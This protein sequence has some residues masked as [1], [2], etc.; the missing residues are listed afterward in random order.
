MT[1]DD[2]SRPTDSGTNTGNYGHPVPTEARQLVRCGLNAALATVDQASGHPYAS[3]ITVATLSEGTPIALL[4][5][6]ARHTRN[7]DRNTHASLLYEHQASQREDPL[8][9]ARLT[10]MGTMSPTPNPFAAQR[11]LARHPEA[12]QYAEFADFA[13]YSFA[14]EE[15]HFIGGFGRIE[16]LSASQLFPSHLSV[17]GLAKAEEE[18]I[19]ALNS[20]EPDCARRLAERDSAGAEPASEWRITGIDAAGIDL[21]GQHLPD[22]AGFAPY[23]TRRADFVTP[24]QSVAEVEARVDSLLA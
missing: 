16:T 5:G 4:S 6:L 13:Y 20:R 2:S 10:L 7:L 3:L 21:V 17:P 18:L 12:E 23:C 14:V 9:A 1:V 8:A 19:A 24:A 15:A 22:S 11:F